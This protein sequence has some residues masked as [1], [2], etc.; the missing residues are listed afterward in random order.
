MEEANSPDMWMKGYKK[1]S[2]VGANRNP[3]LSNKGNAD[4]RVKTL[5]EDELVTQLI[6]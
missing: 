1:K 6:V 4:G 2:P 3:L 5:D